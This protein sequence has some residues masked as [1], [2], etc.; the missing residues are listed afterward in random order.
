MYSF[1]NFSC[2]LGSISSALGSISSA[3]PLSVSRGRHGKLVDNFSPESDVTSPVPVTSR[4]YLDTSLEDSFLFTC[5]FSKVSSSKNNECPASSFPDLLASCR[6]VLVMRI[7]L[8]LSLRGRERSRQSDCNKRVFAQKTPRT[9]HMF[10]RVS[11]NL[12][13]YNHIRTFI[14][15]I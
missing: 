12:Y 6:A 13:V 2:A 11:T 9:S 1:D 8:K 5:I 10:I 4:P 7:Q 3:L 14:S 15:S